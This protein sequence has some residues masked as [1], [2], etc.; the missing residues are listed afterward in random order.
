MEI[1]HQVSQEFEAIRTMAIIKVLCSTGELYSVP[2]AA[3][4]TVQELKALLEKECGVHASRQRLFFGG[5][6]LKDA[7]VTLRSVGVLEHST[8]HL[9]V[10]IGEVLNNSEARCI[11]DAN[12][13]D[14]SADSPLGAAPPP[15][16]SFW[17]QLFVP[18]HSGVAVSLG[19]YADSAETAMQTPQV[20]EP[21]RA[22]DTTTSESTV[23]FWY[24]LFIPQD[25]GTV[26]T[27]GAYADPELLPDDVSH[28]TTDPPPIIPWD[29]VGDALGLTPP[30]LNFMRAEENQSEEVSRHSPIE[31]S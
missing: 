4:G 16:R 6:E 28:V 3:D 19:A 10:R 27:L 31:V 29:R 21:P 15:Q 14:V 11:E 13:G 26:A 18:S 2:F 17:E 24:R 7:S 30:D 20:A 5:R 8:L 23:P 1:V 22:L 9:H 12:V 25:T